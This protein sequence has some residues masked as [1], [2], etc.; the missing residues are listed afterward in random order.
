MTT[1]HSVFK[2][3]PAIYDR[4]RDITRYAEF[5]R[6]AYNIVAQQQQRQFR[7]LTVLSAFPMEGKTLFCA[8]V[9]MAYAETCRSSVLAVDATTYRNPESLTLR[10]CIDPSFSQI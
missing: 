6:L 4:L 1:K 7:S 3:K 8:A 9:A 5:K 10:D 2:D